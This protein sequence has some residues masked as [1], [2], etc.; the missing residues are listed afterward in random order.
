MAKACLNIYATSRVEGGGTG[1]D[2]ME[3]WLSANNLLIR[4]TDL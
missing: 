1:T 4:P 3:C 2:T